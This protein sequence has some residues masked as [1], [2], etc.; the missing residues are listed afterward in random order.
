M[1]ALMAARSASWTRR[2][3]GIDDERVS[4]RVDVALPL[5]MLPYLFG[6]LN[7]QVLGPV[8]IC[9][10]GDIG[11]QVLLHDPELDAFVFFDLPLE[12]SCKLLV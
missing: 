6:G 2:V 12:L 4:P 11:E 10:H 7:A 1:P 8:I 5:E 3:Q 9:W